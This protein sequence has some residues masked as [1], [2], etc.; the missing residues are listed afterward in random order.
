MR[1]IKIFIGTIFIILFILILWISIIS[2]RA[3][4]IKMEFMKHNQK[5]NKIESDLNLETD[6]DY[7]KNQIRKKL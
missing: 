3:N 2:I 1:I 7:Y 5:I 4:D 6:R